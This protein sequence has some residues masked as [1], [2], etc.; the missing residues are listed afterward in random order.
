MKKSESITQN[1][2]I[3]VITVELLHYDHTVFVILSDRLD[4]LLDSISFLSELHVGSV[5]Y[6]IFHGSYVSLFHRW[7]VLL[8]L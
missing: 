3:N 4:L 7:A 2:E 1:H 8:Y 5:L 6:E